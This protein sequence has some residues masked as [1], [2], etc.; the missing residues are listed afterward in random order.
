[1]DLLLETKDLA[2]VQRLLTDV[3]FKWYDIGLQLGLDPAKLECIRQSRKT[4]GECLVDMIQL[5]LK[6]VEPKPTWTH[7]CQVLEGRVAKEKGVAATIRKEKG[8]RYPLSL[9]NLMSIKWHCS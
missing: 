8:T 9:L 2:E 6:G 3:E 5:W 7:L 4:N 1:M